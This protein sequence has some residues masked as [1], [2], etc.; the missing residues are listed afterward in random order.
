MPVVAELYGHKFG[1][2]ESLSAVSDAIC[3]YTQNLCDG[4]GNRD[5]ANIALASDSGIRA[6]YSPKVIQS[7]KVSCAICS[8]GMNDGPKII[9]PRRLLNFGSNGFSDQHSNVVKLLCKTAGFSSNATVDFWTELSL[10]FRQG[11]LKFIYRL[12]YLLRERLPDGSHGAPIIVEIMTCS[13][14]GGNKGLGTDIQT[15]FRKAL[16]ANQGD[17]VNCPGINIRQVWA[18][19][20]SQ[21]IVKSEAALAWAAKLFG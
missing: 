14:S 18:R 9:C 3:P 8:I 13:T 5:M 4:G 16:L 2:A 6:R 1:S 12:D 17:A 21:L 15:A 7:G 19:M 20:A 11:N 10:N